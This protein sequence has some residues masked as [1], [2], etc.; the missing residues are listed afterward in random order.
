MVSAHQPPKLRHDFWL[1]LRKHFFVI[2][3]Q[4]VRVGFQGRNGGEN[5]RGGTGKN[6]FQNSP[7]SWPECSTSNS[8][9]RREKDA[10]ESKCGT[11]RLTRV[12]AVALTVA[13]PVSI[14]ASASIT[15]GDSIMHS[16]RLGRATRFSRSLYP[17]VMPFIR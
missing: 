14:T 2:N 6:I 1:D 12:S 11:E 17:F 9:T 4:F 7:N 10:A 3:E 8:P 5:R 16:K 15:F 13:A